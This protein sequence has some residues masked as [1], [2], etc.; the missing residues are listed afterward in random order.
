M[1][2]PNDRPS[3]GGDPPAKGAPRGGI[4]IGALV[5]SLVLGAAA[6]LLAIGPMVARKA[7]YVSVAHAATGAE[8]GDAEGKADGEH[9]EAKEGEEGATTLH[10][11]DNLVL[12]PAGSG[13]SR[14]LMLA[15]ALELV[16]AQ[17]VD[18]M[19]ARD[20]EARDVVLR[21]LGGRTVEELAEMS[22]REMLKREL[23]D[24]LGALFGKKKAIRRV[25]FPQFVIQ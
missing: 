18:E 13:G 4:L 5:G 22:N 3:E 16:D 10:L 25:Y 8:D 2:E 15:A 20:A 12:N 23:A 21:V 1:S 14:F 19:K 6:G 9:G 24:S 17:S 7:G 11:I